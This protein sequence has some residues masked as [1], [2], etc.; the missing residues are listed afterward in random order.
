MLLEGDE[1][2]LDRLDILGREFGEGDTTMHLEGTDRRDDDRCSW[3]ETRCPAPDVPE[4]LHPEITS[5]ARL[6]DDDIATDET[7]P[8]RADRVTTTR[9]IPEW[10]S[11]HDSAWPPERPDEARGKSTV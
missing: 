2:A 5:E 8:G 1:P 6:C 10:P 9:D 11:M 3:L 7:C 4:L